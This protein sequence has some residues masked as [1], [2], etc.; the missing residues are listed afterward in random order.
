MSEF[1]V[2]GICIHC[3]ILKMVK[4]LWQRRL[5]GEGLNWIL[6]DLQ[7]RREYYVGEGRED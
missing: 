7:D 6:M 5:E 2:W 4:A 3:K 1:V